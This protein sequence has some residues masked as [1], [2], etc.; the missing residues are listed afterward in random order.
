MNVVVLIDY[1][2]IYK[3]AREA[4]FAPTDSH[5]RG[6]FDPL[7]L[8]LLLASKRPIGA[9]KVER[10]LIATRVYSGSPDPRKSPQMH[11]AHS[12]QRLAW[13]KH[14]SV[15]AITRPLQYLPGEPPRQKGVDV[16]LAV[17]LVTIWSE[18]HPQRIPD[19]D[20]LVVASTDTDLLPAVEYLQ[21]R[22]EPVV[23]VAS[24]WAAH[25]QKQIRSSHGRVWSHRLTR[26]DYDHVAD[27]RD[28][29]IE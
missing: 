1:Q 12:R 26:D 27:P 28:Y 23:E 4:F 6:Q 25:F 8:G 10:R 15:V 21:R 9:E 29:N 14:P 22:G 19:C 7:N 5:R 18:A 13:E 17:D 20:I 24:W 3:D 16:A 11:A 2:N